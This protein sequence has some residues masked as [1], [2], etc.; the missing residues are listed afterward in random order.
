MGSANEK[1]V[2][3]ASARIQAAPERVYAIIADYRNGHPH[4]LP[5]QFRGLTVEQGGA[6]AGTI[7]RFEMKAFGTTQ[8]FRASVSEP[9]PGRV[10]VET[11]LEG[12]D[13]VTTFTVDPGP[14][15]GTADVVISTEAGS[16]SGLAGAIERLLSR[17]Y[18][19]SV[20][21]RELALLAERAAS[22]SLA[23]DLSFLK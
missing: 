4:I 12:N 2:V 17:R 19:R 13:A 10:L 21:A 11:N 1:Y 8:R 9:A 20:Y 23:D 14:S 3:R 16:R 5:K 6:G 7:I 15:E 22:E 18:L